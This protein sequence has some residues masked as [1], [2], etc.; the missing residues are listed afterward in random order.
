MFLHL[1]SWVRHNAWTPKGD[2]RPITA[3]EFPVHPQCILLPS[4][5]VVTA[6]QPA[7]TKPVCILHLSVW[8][9]GTEPCQEFRKFHGS[10]DIDP[11]LGYQVPVAEILYY[12]S[13]NMNNCN[14]NQLSS[15]IY[16][17]TVEYQEPDSY[18]CSLEEN[19]KQLATLNLLLFNL[20]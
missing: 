1:W 13:I 8:G 10:P 7:S 6:A 12:T 3:R 19:Y 4:S 9:S 5:T 14:S 11:D 2:F 15:V 16:H 18:H 20:G 17:K